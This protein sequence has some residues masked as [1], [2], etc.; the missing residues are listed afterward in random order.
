MTEAHLPPE[1]TRP[2][3]FLTGMVLALTLAAAWELAWRARGFVPSVSNSNGLWSVWRAESSHDARSVTLVGSSRLQAAMDLDVLARHFPDRRFIQLSVN[4]GYLL[5][6][7]R[8]FAEDPTF[9]GTLIA[10][11]LPA[12]LFTTDNPATNTW[13]QKYHARA[14]LDGVETSVRTW[15]SSRLVSLLPELGTSSIPHFLLERHSAPPLPYYRMDARRQLRMSFALA[16]V[17]EKNAFFAAALRNYGTVATDAEMAARLTQLRAWVAAIT[18]RGGQ[19]I[20]F[21]MLATHDVLATEQER[22]PDARYWALIR[23]AFPSISFQDY[24]TM[25]AFA[26]PDGT[27]IDGHDA[28]PFTEIFAQALRDKQLI[29]N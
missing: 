17:A 9:H 11:V 1:G 28:A 20:F 5:G 21:R 4:S 29:K 18:A 19:V 22:F 3:R 6:M 12:D 10:E 14:P 25:Q 7:L 26:C 13:V 23:D 2:R 15:F 16:N 24:P 27:H 8:D